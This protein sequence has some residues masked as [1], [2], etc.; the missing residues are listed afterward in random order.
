M[1]LK[2]ISK[3]NVRK[4]DQNQKKREKRDNLSAV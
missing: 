3:K 4:L 1:K 2:G